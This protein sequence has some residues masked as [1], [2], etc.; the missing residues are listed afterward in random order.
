MEN[1][2]SVQTRQNTDDVKATDLPTQNMGG[3]RR[4]S[5]LKEHLK[6]SMGSALAYHSIHRFHSAI[7]LRKGR[8]FEEKIKIGNRMR[9]HLRTSRFC[10]LSL[11][12]RTESESSLTPREKKGM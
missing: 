5:H 7:T 4:H 3:G 1:A 9:G 12:E 8:K 11:L 6:N 10:G 2:D